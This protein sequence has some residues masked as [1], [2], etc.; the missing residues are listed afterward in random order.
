[1][2][3]GSRATASV[4]IPLRDA[5]EYLA[6]TALRTQRGIQWVLTDADLAA[7]A[8]NPIYETGSNPKGGRGS[9]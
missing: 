4:L 5:R 6:A 8:G 3:E 2:D 1:M 9:T 7:R